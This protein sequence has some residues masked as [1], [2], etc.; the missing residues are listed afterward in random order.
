M[1][2]MINSELLKRINDLEEPNRS[3]LT[4]LLQD[5]DQVKQKDEVRNSLRTSI[6]DYV[7]KEMKQ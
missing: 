1:I 7:A 6:R 4:K 5:V 2:I 3:I